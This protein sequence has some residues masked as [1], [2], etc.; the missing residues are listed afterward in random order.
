[1]RLAK[2]MMILGLIIGMTDS[3][4]IRIMSFFFCS[5][6]L[7]SFLCFLRKRYRQWHSSPTCEFSPFKN[8]NYEMT[9]EVRFFLGIKWKGFFGFG[10]LVLVY[11]LP[12]TKG[13][14]CIFLANR[15]FLSG[16]RVRMK[17]N[18]RNRVQ[19]QKENSRTFLDHI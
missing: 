6:F 4:S 13:V 9:V 17:P 8:K 7:L 19:C 15:V 3:R 11:M 16:E 1:M 14:F 18:H 10:V 2:V 5:I 12:S